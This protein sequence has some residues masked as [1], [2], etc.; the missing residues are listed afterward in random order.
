MTLEFENDA[1]KSQS[2]SVEEKDELEEVN[3]D[4]RKKLAALELEKEK[5]VTTKA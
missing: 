1:F 2:V 5:L 3:E 4:L